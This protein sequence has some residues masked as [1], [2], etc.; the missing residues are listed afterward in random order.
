MSITST[1]E[2][3]TTFHHGKAYGQHGGPIHYVMG[4][5]GPVLMLIHGWMGTWYSWRKV[6][7]LLANHFT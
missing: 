3:N 5:T 1:P 7:P 2:F 4:G 6:M